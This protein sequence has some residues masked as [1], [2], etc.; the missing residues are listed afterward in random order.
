MK[1][2]EASGREFACPS[3]LVVVPVDGP[4][5]KA[6]LEHGCARCGSPV[7]TVDFTAV[8]SGTIQGEVGRHPS[9]NFVDPR[10]NPGI[11]E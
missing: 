7:T 3:C 8:S 4:A 2:S 5:A 11:D 1:S 9:R 6:L 10:Y